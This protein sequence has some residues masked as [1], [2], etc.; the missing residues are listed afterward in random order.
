MS[1]RSRLI[2]Y[3]GSVVI[4]PLI[5]SLWYSGEHLRT[6]LEY[7]VDRRLQECA[8][9]LNDAFMAEE[10]ELLRRN[11]ALDLTAEMRAFRATGS[12]AALL[13]CLTALRAQV[14]LDLLEVGDSR[15][16]VVARGHKPGDW[17]ENKQ[18][19]PIVAQALAER[20][21][22]DVEGGIN[23]FA[24]R[25]VSPIRDGGGIIGT[26]MTGRYL[27][28]ARV[29]SYR[30]LTSL[31]TGF[32]FG[33]G[34]SFTTLPAGMRA[35]VQA[36]LPVTG[37]ITTSVRAQQAEYRVVLLPLRR[38]DGTPLGTIMTASNADASAEYYRRTLTILLVN[39]AAG[40]ALALLIV[41]L[42]ARRVT[43]PLRQLTTAMD[44]LG[45][46]RLD[47]RLPAGGDDEFGHLQREFNAMAEHLEQATH[48]MQQM[49]VELQRAEKLALAGKLLAEVAHEVRNPLN[50]LN[51][52][53]A[54]LK[55]EL[56]A[57]DRA[58]CDQRLTVIHAEIE[59]LNA[60]VS[61]FLA[62]A[63]PLAVKLR[64]TDL[65][66]T[67]QRALE[68]T[69]AVR[70]ARGVALQT[71]GL[72][73][74]LPLLHDGDLLYRAVLNVLNN[75]LDSMPHGGQLTVQAQRGVGAW[76]LVFSDT[77]TGM[78]SEEQQ[79][80][81]EP[82]FTT[83]E[84]GTGLGLSFALKVVEAHRG[85]IHLDSWP[86]QGTSVTLRFPDQTTEL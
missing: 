18:A 7:E 54:L 69:A 72:T 57:G 43:R 47:M 16:V 28:Q 6:G 25:A 83:K 40:L 10:G 52:N 36:L 61:G 50:G 78:T 67:V 75:A 14:G 65:A 58:R 77:G 37:R 84:R 81:W 73:A 48:R 70:T 79:R 66:Q 29:E 31:E 85:Q 21:A 51:A 24:L 63:A 13:A 2:L 42:L 3:F 15:G 34:S 11:A 46:G 64:A 33:D 23:G 55:K 20:I 44:V 5:L 71:A 30:R 39:A 26:L 19:T 80:V 8:L 82:F 62:D 53:L 22:V 12:R 32:F 17:G 68:F 74:P 60:A 38:H 86:G 59:R 9:G 1:F 35:P 56:R 45:A 4:L 49:Q 41:V 76:E 27:D